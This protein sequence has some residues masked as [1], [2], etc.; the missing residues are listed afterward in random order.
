MALNSN[1]GAVISKPKKLAN[2]FEY[3][4]GEDQARYILEIEDSN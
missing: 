3:F 1:F 4:F 2:L